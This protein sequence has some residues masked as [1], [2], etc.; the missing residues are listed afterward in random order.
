MASNR[1]GTEKATTSD[2]KMTFYGSSFITDEFGNRVE[3]ANRTDQP[4]LMPRF[5]LAEIRSYRET[6]G[7]YRDRRPDQYAALSTMDGRV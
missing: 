7:V 3:V 6:W 4:V 5:D 2:M 1:I